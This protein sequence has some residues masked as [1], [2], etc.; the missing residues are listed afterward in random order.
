MSERMLKIN[1]LLRAELAQLISQT[2]IISDALITITHVKCSP[3]LREA[4]IL[5]SVL[6]ET[7]TGSALKALRSHSSQFSSVL[8]KKI[9]IKMIPKFNWKVDSQERHALDVDHALE[10]LRHED[11]RK[12]I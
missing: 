4:T 1:E 10:D 9:N 2:G 11:E 3:N 12:T 7:M 8:R 5:I 6:P